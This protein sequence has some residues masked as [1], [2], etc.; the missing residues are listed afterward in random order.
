[1]YS[2][3]PAKTPEA[4]VARISGII[5]VLLAGLV[6]AG[7]WNAPSY[8]GCS[9]AGTSWKYT[10]RMA[11]GDEICWRACVRHPNRRVPSTLESIGDYQF[12]SASGLSRERGQHGQPCKLIWI[13]HDAD[14]ANSPII[15]VECR[16]ATRSCRSRSPRL[17]AEARSGFPLGARSSN[18]F[19]CL[20]P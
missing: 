2:A 13:V 16:K 17:G 18:A 1:M 3:A 5:F 14:T 15:N 7:I 4:K 9:A 19:I 8:Q 11:V 20:I 12:E 10:W 6:R